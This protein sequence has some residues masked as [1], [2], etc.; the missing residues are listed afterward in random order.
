MPSIPRFHIPFSYCSLFLLSFT[1]KLLER[2]LCTDSLCF[3]I[4]CFLPSYDS[5]ILV[6]S[7]SSL[8]TTNSFLPQGPGTCSI[9]D[10]PPPWPLPEPPRLASSLLRCHGLS[11]SPTSLHHTQPLYLALF[12]SQ[13][14]WSPPSCTIIYLLVYDCLLWPEHRL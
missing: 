5:A 7:C 8:D 3:P 13:H 14:K 12:S 4:S 1:G 10:A 6:P 11:P 2:V 9:W